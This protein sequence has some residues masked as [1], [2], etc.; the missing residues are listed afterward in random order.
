MNYEAMDDS[1]HSF[2]SRVEEGK[3]K[4]MSKAMY[5]NNYRL[6]CMSFVEMEFSDEEEATLIMRFYFRRFL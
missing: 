3:W 2:G 5:K 1:R 4:E 6:S